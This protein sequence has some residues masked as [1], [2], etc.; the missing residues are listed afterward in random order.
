[1]VFGDSKILLLLWLIPICVFLSYVEVRKV[2]RRFSDFARLRMEDLLSG[3]WS[4]KRAVFKSV[5]LCLVLVLLILALARPR[6]GFEW[7]EV[8]RGGT[9]IVVALDLSTSM[10]ATDITPNRMERAKREI[11]DLLSLLRG[12]RVGI[13]AFAGV[14]FM[15][16]PLT[17]DYR[18]VDMFLKQL[19]LN[20]MP[21]QGTAIGE[22]LDKSIEA[23]DKNAKSDSQAKAIIL[24]TDGEDQEPQTVLMMAKKA[25]EKGI[26]IFPIGI[27]SEQ[28]APIPM[29]DGGF[30][31]DKEGNIVVSKLGEETLKSIA[32]E[33]GG[34]YVRSTTG[35]LDLDAI[36]RNIKTG[37][38]T[39]GDLTRQK[40]WHERFQV[41]LGL[42]LFL[43]I[44]EFFFRSSLNKKRRRWWSNAAGLMLVSAFLSPQA[45]KAG[46][47]REGQ[48]AYEHKD[49]KTAS[50]KFMSA[51]IKEP[52]E[53]VH[54]Y[55]RGV[56]QYFDKKYKEAAEAFSKSAQSQDKTLAGKS[57]YN[58]GN[59]QVSEGNL[60]EAVKAYEKA[61]E[62]NP[63]DKEAQENLEWVKKKVE[64]QKNKKEDEKKDDKKDDKKDQN[65]EDKKDDQKQDQ[66]EEKNDKKDQ[67]KDKQGNEDKDKK[68]KDEQEKKEQ[69]SDKKEENQKDK[70]A[71]QSEPSEQKDTQDNKESQAQKGETKEISKE[72]A[73]KLLRMMED[74]EQVYGM[75]PQY[76][77]PSKKP[78]RDW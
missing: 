66:K 50:D 11:I 10:L 45:A 24:I 46:D 51:E 33:T 52:D 78:E 15:Y 21:V 63:Q 77:K 42:A 4:Y 38:D 67:D 76:Q 29:P 60:E 40:I 61:L 30:K 5:L 54:A 58:L 1:M 12:D 32:S 25:K 22:A 31:K 69:P 55:N 68:Q 28:G 2:R 17:V 48:K 47:A 65:K 3:V 19:N 73:E 53:L 35:S 41:F 14:A 56:S 64:E 34:I 6:W 27:G 57:Y 43:L 59:T 8:S 18:L 44:V 36:Y 26:K 74:Q 72:Q 20:M 7:R 71:G 37:G 75:P 62:I 23:L 13:L 39:E 70:G 9:D 49:Y 16:T